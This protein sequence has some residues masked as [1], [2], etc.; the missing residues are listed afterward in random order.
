MCLINVYPFQP[1]TQGVF[2]ILAPIAI[3][4]DTPVL[5]YLCFYALSY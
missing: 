2:W 1:T 4:F 5:I 3:E